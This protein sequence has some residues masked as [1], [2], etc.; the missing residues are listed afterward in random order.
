MDEWLDGRSERSIGSSFSPCP[1]SSS[2][3]NY[4]SHLLFVWSWISIDYFVLNCFPLTTAVFYL[5]NQR[6]RKVKG[7]AKVVYQVC[8]Q[9]PLLR[10]T[11]TTRQILFWGR[12]IDV[13]WKKMWRHPQSSLWCCCRPFFF[14][15]VEKYFDLV[16]R[17]KGN[18]IMAE[19]KCGVVLVNWRKITKRRRRRSSSRRRRRRRRRRRKKW[20]CRLLYVQIAGWQCLQL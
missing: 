15:G 18:T 5:R 16:I 2:I 3:L 1:F 8:E 19:N 11:M 14:C 20:Q 13:H 12:G 7:E 10:S 17:V 6:C 4:T 9:A